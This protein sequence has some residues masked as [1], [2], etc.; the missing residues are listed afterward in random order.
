MKCPS[1]LTSLNIE[2]VKQK[3]QC[4]VLGWILSS[5]IQ[6]HLAL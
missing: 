6:L 2:Q 3:N 4:Q 5:R 1:K